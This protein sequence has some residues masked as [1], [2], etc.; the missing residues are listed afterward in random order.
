[1][2]KPED[3][4]TQA[5]LSDDSHNDEKKNEKKNV[6]CVNVHL[7]VLA[8]SYASVSKEAFITRIGN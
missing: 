1:M 6:H 5:P 3:R 7:P 8:A 4:S 2:G